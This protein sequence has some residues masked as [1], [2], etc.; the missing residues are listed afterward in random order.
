[1][2]NRAG[3]LSS[4]VINAGGNHAAGKFPVLSKYSDIDV[5]IMWFFGAGIAVELIIAF[6]LLNYIYKFF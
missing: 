4:E 1:M 6:F 3:T 2:L 5:F